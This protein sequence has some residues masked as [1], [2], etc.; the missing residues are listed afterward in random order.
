MDDRVGLD[1]ASFPVPVLLVSGD[2]SV[3]HANIYA[4]QLFSC[5]RGQLVG[6][7]L[8]HLIHSDN[9]PEHLGPLDE[10]GVEVG[11][12]PAGLRREF[13]WVTSKGRELAVEVDIG[14]D[15]D[16]GRVAVIRDISS[17]VKAV[18]ELRE[19]E[20]RL[21]I[22]VEHTADVIQF[23]DLEQDCYVWYGNIDA[24]MGYEPGGFPRSFIGWAELLHPD[25][26]ERIMST[27]EDIVAAGGA[28]WHLRYRIRAADGSYRHWLDRGTVTGY[29]DGRANQGIGAIV[30]ET[31]HMV[32][33]Q[34]LE[35][36]L[37]E[38][39]AL[40]DRLVA[41]SSYLQQ[42][43]RS[44]H[45][46]DEI[47]GN[48]DVL[49]A[50]L[51]Q[52][53][54]VAQTDATVLLLGETGTGKELLA[55]AIHARSA[56]KDRPLIKVDCVTLPPTLIESELFGHRKGAFTGAHE[57]KV[58]RFELAHEATI[59][60]DEIGDLPLDLQAKLLRV[61]ELGQF[62]RV[63]GKS[64]RVV[65]VRVIAATN[66]DLRTEVREGRFRADLFYR[67]SVFPIEAP[68][69]RERREDIPAL[70][71]LFVSRYASAFGKKVSRVSQASMDAM[72]AY[73]WP[74]NVRE[75]R[76]VIERSMILCTSDTL[77]VDPALLDAGTAP[78]AGLSGGALKQD[79]RAVERAR[80]VLALE[81]ARWKIK[82]EGNAADRLGVTPS[83][84]RARMKRLGITRP[85]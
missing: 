35:L 80:I 12:H 84:L 67:L 73:G 2:G 7:D 72:I 14:A 18:A 26:A 15:Q 79:L 6:V 83:G 49:A 66:R 53:E 37:A 30:D 51:K 62:Q 68:P 44:S 85:A 20:Q 29:L 45:G 22:G 31:E 60:L 47:I 81:E 19:S 5:E 75:L 38:V 11:A 34:K 69:L 36:A 28:G 32:A 41:E 65:D 57:S 58:G 33:R 48:S 56:R 77:A 61:I 27:I 24:L 82:G 3:A 9:R 25:D 59:L 74:G 76:N 10:I 70:V 54:S 52:I 39:S 71:S 43:I 13:G 64:E 40:K 23:L 16:G 42:E 21:G 4:E 8:E 50:T 55:R 1:I 46:F 78:Q 63:G 17:A